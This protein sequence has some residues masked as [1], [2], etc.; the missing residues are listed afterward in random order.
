[1]ASEI[2]K[3]RRRR[4]AAQTLEELGR[5]EEH[6]LLVHYSCES[7][8]DRP[9]GQTPRVTSIAVRNYL[10]AQTV[11]FS[12]HKI[13]EIERVSFSDIENN[14]DRLEKEML[15]EFFEFLRQRKTHIWV[16]WNMRDI[17]YGFPAL[18]HRFRV[19]GGQPEI[20]EDS[21]KV[22]LARLLISLYGGRYTGHPRLE[23]LMKKN[24]MSDLNFLTGREEADAFENKEH[25]K[26]HQSTLR[27]VDVFSNI[28]GRTLDG[29]LRTNARWIDIHGMNPKLWVEVAAQHWGFI[30]F[31]FVASVISIGL[32]IGDIF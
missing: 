20:L 5:K 32:K 11:S 13:A 9:E 17:N 8:Y 2:E 7:F 3:R 31:G 21:Q 1:M 15:S 12:I 29:S 14:Y 10:S 25:V 6:V 28:L 30:L 23:T 24:R 4:V 22:D 26:L 18:E 27:K 16:H 19:L